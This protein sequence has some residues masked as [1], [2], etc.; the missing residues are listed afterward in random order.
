MFTLF[1]C[2]GHSGLCYFAH[3]SLS[4]IARR[5]RFLEASD[6]FGIISSMVFTRYG[7]PIG[8]VNV[9][10]QAWCWEMIL[11]RSISKLKLLFGPCTN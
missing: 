10:E 1:I 9:L 3:F 4:K 11:H 5:N 7:S 2:R 6:K 8:M